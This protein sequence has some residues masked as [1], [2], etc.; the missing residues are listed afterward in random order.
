MM[1]FS[2]PEHDVEIP[3]GMS[4]VRRLDSYEASASETGSSCGDLK[5]EDDMVSGDMS[6]VETALQ[7]RI[8]AQEQEIAAFDSSA[9]AAQPLLAIAEDGSSSQ[10]GEEV[11]V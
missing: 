3:T 11:E 4:N 10:K 9:T 8:D 2:S 1:E 6:F 7:K 5:E